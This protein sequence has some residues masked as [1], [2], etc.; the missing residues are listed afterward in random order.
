MVERKTSKLS[1]LHQRETTKN[2]KKSF[3]LQSIPGA[4]SGVKASVDASP[5][6]QHSSSSIDD[7]ISGD[8][9]LR[10][11]T[12]GGVSQRDVEVL[13]TRDVAVAVG[14][15]ASLEQQHLELVREGGSQGAPCGA[16]AH[17]D[18]VVCF[19]WR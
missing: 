19:P 14:G 17:Y 15:A 1:T 5:T 12:R 9:S 16:S 2:E 4:G 3:G 6:T 11:R 10:R 18:V 7:S 8:E 13:Q